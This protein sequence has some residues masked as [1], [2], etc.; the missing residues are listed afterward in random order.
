M[1]LQRP[2]NKSTVATVRRALAVACVLF[3]AAT[4]G[5]PFMRATTPTAGDDAA[6]AIDFSHAGYGGGGVPLPEVAAVVTVRPS[7]G[8]DTA[9]LQAA[10]D[11]VA[12]LPPRADGFRG[13]L[14]L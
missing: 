14:Q 11:H 3:V 5:L 12:S 6:T 13:A 9:R 1:S 10:L 7:G 2:N 8:D 4:G